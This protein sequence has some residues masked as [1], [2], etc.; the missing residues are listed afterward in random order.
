MVDHASASFFFLDVAVMTGLG[1]SLEREFVS[2]IM[3]DAMMMLLYVVE[4][5]IA[6]AS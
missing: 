6:A 1:A 2:A 3:L 4:P 5:L